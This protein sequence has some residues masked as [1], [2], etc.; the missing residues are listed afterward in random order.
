MAA[1]PSSSVPV[2]EVVVPV[3][4]HRRRRPRDVRVG[5]RGGGSSVRVLSDLVPVTVGRDSDSFRRTVTLDRPEVGPGDRS[6]PFDRG[7]ETDH[8]R[9]TV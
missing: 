5:G 3:L 7:E 8:R 1:G 9:T 6:R 2:I 4:G